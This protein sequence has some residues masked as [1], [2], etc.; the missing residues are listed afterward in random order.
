MAYFLVKKEI[1]LK[2]EPTPTNTPWMMDGTW[3][4]NNFLLGSSFPYVS[5]VAVDSLFGLAVVWIV[6]VCLIAYVYACLQA[7]TDIYTKEGMSIREH[8]IE[9][10]LDLHVYVGSNLVDMHA[11]CEAFKVLGDYS[12]RCPCLR[13]F[14]LLHVKHGQWQKAME[15]FQQI[16]NNKVYCGILLFL[17]ECWMQL[18]A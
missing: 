3:S 14:H 11:K 10:V 13:I 6:G 9:S 17:W 15:L 7:W 18:L 4:R 1:G 8:I 2:V 5:S 12:T 16:H